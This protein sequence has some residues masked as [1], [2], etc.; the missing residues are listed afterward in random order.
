MGRI[1]D[2]D[3]KEIK[4]K[5]DEK[6]GNDDIDPYTQKTLQAIDSLRDMLGKISSDLDLTFFQVLG[7][8]TSLQAQL[9]STLMQREH[10]QKTKLT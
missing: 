3:G 5:I 2:I 1:V 8:V 4:C 7:A 9:V 10:S 6:A